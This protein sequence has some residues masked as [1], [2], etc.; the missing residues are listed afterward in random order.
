MLQSN[1]PWARKNIPVEEMLLNPQ[2]FV[3]EK[4]S[5]NLLCVLILSNSLQ[6]VPEGYF[7]LC[8]AASRDTG[9]ITHLFPV[10]IGKLTLMFKVKRKKN[11]HGANQNPLSAPQSPDPLC[12]G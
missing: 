1:L 8:Q 6:S 12:A 4:R 2:C 5:N 10:L 9:D 3:C 7:I 11:L